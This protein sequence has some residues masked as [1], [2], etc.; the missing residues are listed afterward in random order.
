MGLRKSSIL[1]LWKLYLPNWR[2]KINLW[3]HWFI[4][5][6][7]QFCVG[8][9]SVSLNKIYQNTQKNESNKIR[10]LATFMF[11]DFVENAGLDAN[12]MYSHFNL[13]F[14]NTIYIVWS[15]WSHDVSSVSL[16]YIC[17][18]ANIISKGLWK[19]SERTRNSDKANEN[20]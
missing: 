10:I 3:F 19:T 17:F 18:F 8:N 2:D 16:A 5:M 7:P 14:Q 11:C 9:Y 1:P 15:R 13:H 20:K 4:N 12:L 6:L